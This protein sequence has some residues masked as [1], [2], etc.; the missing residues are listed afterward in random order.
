MGKKI[1][2]EPGILDSAILLRDS[3]ATVREY[4]NAMCVILLADEGNNYTAAEVGD[5][6]GI[7]RDTVF[8]IMNHF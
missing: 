7:S 5:L 2:I 6:L 3:A 4:R 1:S 8:E